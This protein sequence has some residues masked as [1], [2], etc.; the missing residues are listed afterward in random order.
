MAAGSNNPTAQTTASSRAPNGNGGGDGSAPFYA[1]LAA[2][3]PDPD[4]VPDAVVHRLRNLLFGRAVRPREATG[5]RALARPLQGKVLT[6]W[7]WMPPN[8]SPGFHSEED[9]YE[10][11]RALNR[12]HI[13]EVEAEAAD[14][15]TNKKKKK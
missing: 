2:R 13:K 11:R 8:E 5:R 6:D 15:G 7:Y 9:E 4:T 14:A 3:Y 12:R 10:L 1:G